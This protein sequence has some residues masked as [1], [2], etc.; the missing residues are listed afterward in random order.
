M[1]ISRIENTLV[2]FEMRLVKTDSAKQ[3]IGSRAINKKFKL[4][5]IFDGNKIVSCYN[6]EQGMIATSCEK[7][8]GGTYNDTTKKCD[9]SKLC[10][11]ETKVMQATATPGTNACGEVF[12]LKTET[13]LVSASTSIIINDGVVKN[14]ISAVIIGGGGGGGGSDGNDQGYGGQVG[15]MVPTVFAV[16]AMDTCILTIGTG[17][18]GGA[19]GSGSDDKPGT[20]GG[21]SKMSCDGIEYT[22]SGGPG[23]GVNKQSGNN[24]D[25]GHGYTFKGVT[26]SGGSGGG[27]DQNGKSGA[28]GAGGGGAGENRKTGG[29]GGS[30]LIWYSYQYLAKK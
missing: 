7:L 14:A 21:T 6:D 28:S 15:T 22:A 16:K 4:D 8:L 3:G 1:S 13:N 26:Y 24:G 11:V 2:E 30:G 20:T 12:E 17:G 27:K 10:E 29:S 18:P 5:A 23:G 19:G 25:S 9:G